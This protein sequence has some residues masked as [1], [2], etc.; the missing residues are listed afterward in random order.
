VREQVLGADMVIGTVLI[1]GKKAPK[2]VTDEMVAQ[3]KPGSVLVDVAI[4][5][6]GCFEGSRPTTHA[7][8]TFTGAQLDLLLRR[9][10][11]WRRAEHLDLGAHQ[12]DPPVCREAR[13]Q[14]LARGAPGRPGAGPGPQHPRR[15]VTYPAVAEAFGMPCTPIAEAIA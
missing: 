12:R 10:H 7:D 11:A 8:P 6:G 5:Q 3:M 2:L 4:D 9:E 15:A 1:P 13:R 14:G